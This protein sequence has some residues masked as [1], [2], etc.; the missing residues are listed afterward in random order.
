[1]FQYNKIS[2]IVSEAIL[3]TVYDKKCITATPAKLKMYFAKMHQSAIENFAET[4]DIKEKA[5]LYKLGILY[6]NLFNDAIRKENQFNG[7]KLKIKVCWQNP[8]MA[9]VMSR[10]NEIR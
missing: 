7:K 9:P 5:H 2:K 4:A 1:M 3:S 8:Q 6:R 10:M